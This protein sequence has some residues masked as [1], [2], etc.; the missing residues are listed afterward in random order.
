[1]ETTTTLPEYEPIDP[2]RLY[3]SEPY[4]VKDKIIIYQPTIQDIIDIGEAK[5]YAMLRVFIQNTT[6]CR[7]M[8]WDMGI[9]W[10]EISDYELFLA[11]VT[12][13]D[14]DKTR[15]LFHEL[16]FT[17]F[18]PYQKIVPNPDFDE[19][20]EEDDKNKKQISETFL[21]D[22]VND[23][24]I[25]E[26]DYKQIAKVLRT[27][28]GIFPKDEFISTKFFREDI[29]AEERTKMELEAKK[30]PHSESTLL[31]LISACVNHPGFK[32]KINELR[33]LGIAAFMD[34]VQRLQIYESST[35][36]LKGMYSGFIDTKGVDPAQFN[37]M[38]EI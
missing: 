11:M 21:Y 16:D 5:F 6:M 27:I 25:N 34:S 19:S 35:A 17:K 8:L 37:F 24:E 36:L 32:Y 10:N 30:H 14:V 20:K 29:I 13:L 4:T 33:D 12:T 15:V 23:I 26:D 38:R 7:V 18:K 2:L 22:P 9:D 31:P 1:M 28:F 3:F